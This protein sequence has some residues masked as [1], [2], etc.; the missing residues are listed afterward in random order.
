MA[1]AEDHAGD[2]QPDNWID[3]CTR[4]VLAENPQ[5]IRPAIFGLVLAGEMREN[6]GQ[7]QHEDAGDEIADE[8][9]QKSFRPEHRGKNGGAEIRHIGKGAH[10]RLHGRR[11]QVMPEHETA[12]P[13]RNHI[14]AHQAQH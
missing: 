2:R 8:H 9:R 11:A 13:E 3:D 6:N 4:D 12:D 1:E 14:G 10:Q 7:R 5:N